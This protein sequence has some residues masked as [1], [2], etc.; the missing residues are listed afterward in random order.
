MLGTRSSKRVAVQGAC[1][2]QIT[3]GTVMTGWPCGAWL[4]E[5][6][7]AAHLA[8]RYFR[9]DDPV[10]SCAYHVALYY[11]DVLNRFIPMI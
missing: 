9:P 5:F 11:L 6:I 2:G 8:I 1:L 10:R 3:V 4:A 7:S